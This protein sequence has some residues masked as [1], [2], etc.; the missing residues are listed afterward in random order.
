MAKFRKKDR[1]VEKQDPKPRISSNFIPIEPRTKNQTA[2]VVSMQNFTI[3]VVIGTA[4]TGKTLLAIS[5][6]LKSLKSGRAKRLV[7]IRPLV[8]VG[9]SL[10]Y[11]P[12]DVVE[13][14][15]PYSTPLLYYI[16]E[17]MNCKGYSSKMI[18]AGVIELVPIALIR[19]RTFTDSFI[20]LDEAQNITPEQMQATL[21]RLGEGSQI[22]LVGDEN[23]SDLHNSKSGLSDLLDRVPPDAPFWDG[24]VELKK[25]DIQRNEVLK[26]IHDWYAA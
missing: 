9:E 12:G 7:L 15:T 8:A 20:L 2:A 11:L 26:E 22:V 19:G 24:V 23:Q 16:D 21:T 18:E 13:K 14:I 5:E 1:K 17:L 10:G 6:A 3:S 4:G 25:V